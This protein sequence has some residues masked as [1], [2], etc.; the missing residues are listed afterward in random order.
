MM[1]PSGFGTTTLFGQILVPGKLFNAYAIFLDSC[2]VVTST[3]S[4]DVP[5]SYHEKFSAIMYLPNRDIQ[6]IGNALHNLQSVGMISTFDSGGGY[7]GSVGLMWDPPVSLLAAC[8]VSGGGT[9]YAGFTGEGANYH[10]VFVSL[11]DAAGGVQWSRQY[12]AFEQDEG[13][14]I[15]AIA[16]GLVVV[17]QHNKGEDGF[18][19]LLSLQGDIEQQVSV[20]GCALSH[21]IAARGGGYIAIG[22]MHVG[23]RTY[24]LLVVGKQTGEIVQL[25]RFELLSSEFPVIL[26]SATELESGAVGLVFDAYGESVGN[27]RSRAVVVEVDMSAG[28]GAGAGSILRAHYLGSGELGSRFYA[29][30][31]S[32]SPQGGFSVAGYSREG[33]SSYNYYFGE[34]TDGF[35]LPGYSLYSPVPSGELVVLELSVAAATSAVTFTPTA[36]GGFQEVSLSSAEHAEPPVAE[37]AV[38][39]A[40]ACLDTP[41]TPR[42]TLAPAAAP[43][44]SPT[45]VAPSSLPSPQPTEQPTS[46][47]PSVSPT[48]AMPT[49]AGDTTRPSAAPSS[50]PTSAPSTPPTPAPSGRRSP[51]PSARPSS[52]PSTTAPSP[53]P[54]EQPSLSPSSAAPRPARPT[55]GPS[56]APSGA[57][58]LGTNSPTQNDEMFSFA[59]LQNDK[60]FV[61][62]VIGTSVLFASVLLLLIGCVIY[63]RK[64]LEFQF[65]PSKNAEILARTGARRTGARRGAIVPS[66]APAATRAVDPGMAGQVK[67]AEHTAIVAKQNAVRSAMTGTTTGTT[68]A[69]SNATELKDDASSAAEEE[70]S[71]STS[72]EQE[73]EEGSAPSVSSDSSGSSGGAIFTRTPRKV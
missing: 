55:P 52:S 46:E 51:A 72:D 41:V 26:R 35:A 25:L 14:D 54:S 29:R 32:P 17:G 45:S 64:N 59:S 37:A 31:L 48:S 4:I 5:D 19:L 38:R 56:P 36:V 49:R 7:K 11:F 44:N 21:V 27:Y 69:I 34:L 30:G 33:F 39:L 9:A 22:E 58:S 60:N 62:F 65:F 2:G 28:A 73:A 10:D 70:A 71:G 3:A 53:R 20:G 50:R 43:S 63:A 57:P 12:A 61:L 67:I 42:P 68:T 18:V 6:L 40:D 1:A 13:H 23:Q 47:A 16:S 15:I 66:A 8:A 24:G